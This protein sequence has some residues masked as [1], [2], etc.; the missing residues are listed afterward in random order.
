MGFTERGSEE[1]RV[2]VCDRTRTH[3]HPLFCHE[4]SFRNPTRTEDEDGGGGGELVEVEV[5]ADELVDQQVFGRRFGDRRGLR[6]ARAKTCR[7]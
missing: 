4:S 6:R 3:P 5:L 1:K 7:S 2:G